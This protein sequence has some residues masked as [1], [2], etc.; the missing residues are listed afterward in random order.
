MVRAAAKAIVDDHQRDSEFTAD[1]SPTGL[2]PEAI[3]DVLI[4]LASKTSNPVW[5]AQY[6]RMA[7]ALSQPS[8]GRPQKFDDRRKL[9]DARALVEQGVVGTFYGACVLIARQFETG[10]ERRVRSTAERLRRKHKK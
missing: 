1:M 8:G 2:P 6:Q 3:A 10:D 9:A 5:R 4:R 7:R